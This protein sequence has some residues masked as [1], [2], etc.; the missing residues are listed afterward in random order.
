[1]KRLLMALGFA[2]AV[3]FTACGASIDEVKEE[4]DRILAEVKLEND[5]VIHEIRNAQSSQEFMDSFVSSLL[6]NPEYKSYLEWSEQDIESLA[7]AFIN[8]PRY[9]EMLQTTPKE[10]CAQIIVMAV[11]IG[12]EHFIPSDDE[13]QELCEWYEDYL[14]SES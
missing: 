7:A 14:E 1:M 8:D 11:I 3:F 12:G 9:A 4:N 2:L 10:D 13:A 5:R 6:S